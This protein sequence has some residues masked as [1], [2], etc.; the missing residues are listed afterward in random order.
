MA[1]ESDEGEIRK[2]G[3]GVADPLYGF[4]EKT[5]CAKEHTWPAHDLFWCD[6][7]EEDGD[8]ERVVDAV[9]AGWYCPQCCVQLEIE[10][11][12][13]PLSEVVAARADFTASIR[14]SLLT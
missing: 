10:C 11:E 1:F 13:P 3:R 8:A 9:E 12:G 7:R 2:P 6:E 4:S 14:R 5:E